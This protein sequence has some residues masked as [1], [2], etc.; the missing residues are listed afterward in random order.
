MLDQ[1]LYIIPILFI[2]RPTCILDS[3]TSIP[4]ESF[5][6]NLPTSTLFHL[7]LVR[8]H[9]CC[10]LSRFGLFVTPQTAAHQAP[11]CMGFPREEYWSELP[12]LSPADLP[13]PGLEPATLSLAALAGRLS[14][15]VLP[16]KP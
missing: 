13:N 8:K 3:F 7:L 15:T 11:L 9:M 2:P 16:G 4:Y 1:S 10:V 14:T 12:F 6:N 5:L